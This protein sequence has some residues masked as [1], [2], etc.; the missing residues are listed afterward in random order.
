MED[1]VAPI[2]A[3]VSRLK[4]CATM[5]NNEGVEVINKR[6][7]GLEVNDQLI[8]GLVKHNATQLNRL[9]SKVEELSLQQD[10]RPPEGFLLFAINELFRFGVEF[11]R[12]RALEGEQGANRAA[13]GYRQREPPGTRRQPGQPQPSIER[14]YNVDI[15][16]LLEVIGTDDE[17]LVSHRD[18]DRLVRMQSGFSVK[19]LKNA[20][21][22]LESN[23]LKN[24]ISSAGSQ[25]MIVDGDCLSEKKGT[26]S[27][28]TVLCA[29]IAA[30][31][32]SNT[33]SPDPGMEPAG[34]AVLFFACSDHSSPSSLLPGP[35]GMMRSLISQLLIARDLPWNPRQ[36]SKGRVSYGR[37]PDLSFLAESSILWPDILHHSRT[38][39]GS[40][41]TA[42]VSKHLPVPS[43]DHDKKPRSSNSPSPNPRSDA[44]SDSGSDNDDE[45]GGYKSQSQ[46]KDSGAIGEQ[47]ALNSLAS[48]FIQLVR[49]LDPRTTVFC[50]LDGASYYE[51]T[52]CGPW[53]SQI[54]QVVRRL[55]DDLWQGG[56]SG[57]GGR[58]GRGAYRQGP[59]FKLLMTSPVRSSTLFGLVKS[60]YAGDGAQ[61]VD[62][63]TRKSPHKT[64]AENLGIRHLNVPVTAARPRS[65]SGRRD[66]YYRGGDGGRNSRDEERY[67]SDFDG[68]YGDGR[69]GR[70][71]GYTPARRVH[72]L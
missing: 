57:G 28:M 35:W 4:D 61:C 54:A 36:D 69:R 39:A 49:Q 68:Y 18:R 47:T 43:L 1:L 56:S 17:H 23:E 58:E 38:G 21:H 37:H 11:S 24:W 25:L 26:A 10:R 9:Y 13:L 64:K 14:L 66:G 44:E 19:A 67:Y 51:P 42:D 27:P 45:T 30:G 52:H 6:V 46:P 8:L 32:T 5:L 3:A 41:S 72:R 48:V 29:S 55:A 70:S 62:M 12:K 65:S 2:T 31:L 16:R 40:H 20:Y 22:I 50:I 33:A 60:S 59:A 34:A 63:A 53:R 71:G 15:N 7:A